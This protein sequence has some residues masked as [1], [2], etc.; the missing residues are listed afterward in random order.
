MAPAG[1]AR[2]RALAGP[3]QP[4]PGTAGRGDK[5]WGVEEWS[6]S[7]RIVAGG[8]VAAADLGGNPQVSR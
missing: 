1:P 4:L 3:A 8:I 2:A 7:F 6:G 5:V